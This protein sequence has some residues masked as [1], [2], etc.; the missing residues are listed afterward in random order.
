MD[1][2]NLSSQ[3]YTDILISQISLSSRF[4]DDK[5]SEN[6]RILVLSHQLSQFG[7]PAFY[8]DSSPSYSLEKTNGPTVIAFD[9][10]SKL[11]EFKIPY[12][13]ESREW[14]WNA[15]SYFSFEISEHFSRALVLL[16]YYQKFNVYSMYFTSYLLFPPQRSIIEPFLFQP[17]VVRR[18]GK[19]H[20]RTVLQGGIEISILKAPRTIGSFVLIPPFE[21]PFKVVEILSKSFDVI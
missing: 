17:V 19:I 8:L 12:W 4:N 21:H 11:S 14:N 1:S 5:N 2:W 15:S 9:I 18:K 13:A 6:L 10:Y 20:I 16:K 3:N 7:I